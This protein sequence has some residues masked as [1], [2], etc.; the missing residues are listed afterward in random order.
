MIRTFSKIFSKNF[1]EKGDSD[2]LTLIATNQVYI[3]LY[4]SQTNNYKSLNHEI[5]KNVTS[6]LEGTTHFDDPLINF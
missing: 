2:F 1:F 4:G 3:L 6:Y 5:L